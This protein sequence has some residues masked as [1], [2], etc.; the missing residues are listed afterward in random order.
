MRIGFEFG[1]VV[2][3]RAPVGSAPGR[4]LSVF[5]FDEKLN[6]ILPVRSHDFHGR[7][8]D[9]FLGRFSSPTPFHF[10]CGCLKIS[11]QHF[12]GICRALP[13]IIPHA[14]PFASSAGYRS[15]EPKGNRAERLLTRHILRY[16]HFISNAY[17]N[18]RGR[19]VGISPAPMSMI[20]YNHFGAFSLKCLVHDGLLLVSV[21]PSDKRLGLIISRRK[22]CPL[23]PS[24]RW[25]PP[26][27]HVTGKEGRAG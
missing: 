8:L 15:S 17:V 14:G 1:S 25:R 2:I 12:E 27:G 21:Q 6:D 10:R 13:L 3:G 24:L 5:R 23:F 18:L 19:A 9:H 7:A 20:H 11:R 22:H 26:R 16:A 4:M